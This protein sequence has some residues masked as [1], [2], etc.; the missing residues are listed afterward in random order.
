MNAPRLLIFAALSGL[1]IS[2]TSAFALDRFVSSG[3][4]NLVIKG[5]ATTSY[6]SDGTPKKGSAAHAVTWKGV[7][8][9]FATA[10]DAAKF[11]AN[12]GAFAPQFGAY[13]TGGLSQRHVVTGNPK[14]WRMHQ[15]KLYLFFARAGAKRFDRD[16]EGTIAK[17]SAFWNTLDVKD[18]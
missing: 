4:D 17:A 10:A 15:G 13:C 16:P 9:R 14:I 1:L 11:K 5:Y 8:W 2:A 6:F 7:T 3:A 18:R 12:P